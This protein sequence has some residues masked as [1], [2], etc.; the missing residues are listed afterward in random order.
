MT[1]TESNKHSAKAKVSPELVRRKVLRCLGCP[2][3]LINYNLAIQSVRN[4]RTSFQYGHELMADLL[5]YASSRT[6]TRLLTQWLEFQ[7]NSGYQLQNVKRGGGKNKHKTLYGLDDLEPVIQWIQEKVSSDSDFGCELPEI[8]ISR[9]VQ[10]G[11]SKLKSKLRLVSASIAL[12]KQKRTDS[13]TNRGGDVLSSTD[14][15]TLTVSPSQGLSDAFKYVFPAKGKVPAISGWRT[16]PFLSSQ[17]K[18][19]VWAKHAGSNVAIATGEKL[20]DGRRLCVLDVDPRNKGD[21][22]LRN[23]LSKYGI[24]LPST[25]TV[26]TGGDGIH[27]YF[28]TDRAFKGGTNVF[29]NGLDFKAAGGYVIGPGS[30]HESG[31]EYVVVNDAS[32]AHLPEA[33][34]SSLSEYVPVTKVSVGQRHKALV[35][36]AGCEIGR[37]KSDEEVEAILWQK[38]AQYETAGREITEKEIAEIIAWVRNRENKA[39]RRSYAATGT[40]GKA[41]RGEGRPRNCHDF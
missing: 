17:A 15:C 5:G 11:L 20:A 36:V 2:A 24:E 34:I 22:S 4:G 32:I 26:K 19:K 25:L 28:S 40:Y 7:R 14:L 23:L 16:F 29:G 9:Y 35:R 12:R 30:T 1:V 27:Y 21:R 41:E 39:R 6:M 8:L 10:A 33:F 31:K 13:K 38:V 37:G 18:A 3:D